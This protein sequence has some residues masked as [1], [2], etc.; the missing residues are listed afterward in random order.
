MHALTTFNQMSILPSQLFNSAFGN[1]AAYNLG[2]WSRLPAWVV[3]PAQLASCNLS[4]LFNMQQ[5]RL[6]ACTLAPLI[7]SVTNHCG[8]KSRT[9][10]FTLH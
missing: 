8:R 3:Y 9:G 10:Q 2:L 7:T 1:Q 5:H 4:F 6:G